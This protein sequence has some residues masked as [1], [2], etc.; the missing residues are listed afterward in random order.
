MPR[1]K[2]NQTPSQRD[3]RRTMIMRDQHGRR[4]SATVETETLAPV[5]ELTP[6]FDAKH[7]RPEWGPAPIMPP[8]GVL[9]F[10]EDD[11]GFF[12]IDYEAWLEMVLGAWREY[13]E[14]LTY[15]AQQLYG[16]AWY[17]AVKNPPSQLRNMVRRREPPNPDQV[18]ACMQ[19]NPFALGLRKPNGELFARPAWAD[20]VFPLAPTAEAEGRS[21]F[22]SAEE[23]E[24]DAKAVERRIL[25]GMKSKQHFEPTVEITDE[26]WEEIEEQTDEDE[27]PVQQVRAAT[28]TQLGTRKKARR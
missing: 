4:W 14:S 2:R 21:L 26:E 22:P 28:G 10:S 12:R 5:G 6:A 18:R 20:E 24:D 17:R 3:Y 25:A 13:Q 15:Y 8:P 9:V 19:G 27:R 11:V 7:H 1:R 23:D 16:D